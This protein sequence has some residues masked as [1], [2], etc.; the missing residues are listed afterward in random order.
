VTYLALFVVGLEVGNRF[1]ASSI[2][3]S[4]ETICVRQ[5]I[6]PVIAFII[7]PFFSLANITRNVLLLEAMMPPAVL[8]VVLASNFDLNTGHAASIVTL[9]TLI[10]LPIVPFIP[11]L[12]Q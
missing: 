11:L 7:L 5:L 2:R 6:V 12:L 4:I 9:G 3:S 10:F 1:S 8:N